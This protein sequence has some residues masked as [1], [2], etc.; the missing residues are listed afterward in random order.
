[1]NHF[2]RVAPARPG[3]SYFD[4]SHPVL[5]DTDAGKLVPVLCEEMVPGDFFKISNECIVRLQ[6]MI[7]PVLHSIHVRVHYFFVPYRLLWEDWEDFITGGTE[8]DDA[9]VIPRWTPDTVAK[10]SL[11]DYLGFPLVV[12]TGLDRPLSFPL[13]AYKFIWNEFYRDQNLQTE[14][15]ITADAV[16]MVKNVDWRKDY[17][18]AGLPWQQRGTAPAFPIAGILPVELDTGGAL[19]FTPITADRPQTGV[20]QDIK[21]TPE[22]GVS[23]NDRPLAV[24]LSNAVTFNVADLRLAVQTQKFLERNARGGVRYTEFLRSHFAVNPRDDRLQRPEYIGGTKQPI[25]ISEVLKTSED[26]ANPQGT[27]A[28]HGLSASM[29]HAASYHAKEFGLVMGLMSIVPECVYNSQGFDRQWLRRDRLDFYFP[30]FSH[31]AE[32]A[33]ERE[34]IYA[35]DVEADNR[36]VWAWQGRYDEMRVKRGKVAGN[37]RDTLN[38]WHMA[39]TFSAAPALNDAFL[40]VDGTDTANLARIFAVQDEPG[41]LVH[42]ANVIKASRPIPIISDPGLLDHF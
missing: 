18:T 37:F 8:G 26:G 16:S 30:E 12:P 39:R 34:E 2:N 24:D 27:L 33:I 13:R 14:L 19:G 31:L 35:T 4:L 21:T 15:D 25:I 3:R 1:M 20:L 42:F 29:A 41:Y 7:A 9:S 11:W 28:G 32:Q 10:G 40:Q 38:Y 17:F 22:A 6:P 23:V 5:F 36:A